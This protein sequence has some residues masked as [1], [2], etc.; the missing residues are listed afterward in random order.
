[1][2]DSN[3][4]MPEKFKRLV[5][6]RLFILYVNPEDAVT[7]ENDEHLKLVRIEPDALTT[8]AEKIWGELQDIDWEDDLEDTIIRTD[9]LILL[10]TEED[11]DTAELLTNSCYGIPEDIA[12][13]KTK[14]Q[15]EQYIKENH[16]PENPLEI[17]T[18][19]LFNPDRCYW[20]SD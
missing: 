2:P 13:F 9:A 5:N 4:A 15:A 20:L 6:Y 19:N 3:L 11:Y 16:D 10:Y 14:A 7:L 1:M 17:Q 12:F 8:L 18:I